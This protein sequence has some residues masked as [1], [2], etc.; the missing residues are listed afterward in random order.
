[1]SLHPLGL[2][3]SH[4]WRG[5]RNGGQLRYIAMG[6][7]A[8]LLGI[9][10]AWRYTTVPLDFVLGMATAMLLM[11]LWWTQIEGLLQQN[12]PMLARLVPGHTAALRRSL[13]AQ[14]ALHTAT[15]TLLLHTRMG[16]DTPWALT[17]L[18]VGTGLVVLAWL[19]SQPLL[20]LPVSLLFFGALSQWR[21]LKPAVLNGW[22][23][24]LTQLAE[25]AQALASLALAAVL[26]AA[27]L[28]PLIGTGHAAHRE[29]AER[30]DRQ[31]AVSR[32]MQS[33][34]GV[35][36]KHQSSA[37]RW[38]YRFIAA[39]WTAL[40]A[41]QLR[42]GVPAASMGRLNLLLAGHSHWARYVGMG[43][44]IA[45]C[46]VLPIALLMA[47][48]PTRGGKSAFDA[49]RFGLCMGVFSVGL[50]PLMQLPVALI[51][52]RREQGL[53]ML[54]PGVPQGAA[55][56]DA[57]CA[58]QLRQFI[59][60][61]TLCTG[62]CMGLTVALG[63]PSALRYV[64]GCAAACLCLSPLVWRDWSRVRTEG[65]WLRN[66]Q[67]SNLAV[68]GVGSIGGAV[69]EH[70]AAPPALSL[71]TGL[72]LAVGAGAWARARHRQSGRVGSPFPVGRQAN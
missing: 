1:M 40:L 67:W 5:L 13:L 11:A 22:E 18:I 70:L 9:A 31:K 46:V 38:L 41:R 34:C 64:A 60:G 56:R 30:R 17:A 51:S 47:W 8:G 20:W 54:A 14:W 6:A 4:I 24:A 48:L 65:P 28:R 68:L 19:V 50:G 23:T 16:P 12:R 44:L 35:P 37:L 71:L 27:L 55:M 3:A 32:A 42:P 39:P 7:G 21:R 15:W 25:P 2:P 72:A 33:G 57:W 36:V 58:Y 63:G 26:L 66:A 62:L 52:H 43:T 69:A 10:L 29:H 53:L 45:I 59:L 49:M 61:W